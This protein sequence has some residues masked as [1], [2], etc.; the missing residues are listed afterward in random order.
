MSEE[1]LRLSSSREEIK[2]LIF[3]VSVVTGL[4]D[5]DE[6][7]DENGIKSEGEKEYPRSPTFVLYHNKTFHFCSYHNNNIGDYYNILNKFH[8]LFK[9]DE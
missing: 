5:T 4:D 9:F 8:K 1:K 7:A 3:P 6:V 2:S